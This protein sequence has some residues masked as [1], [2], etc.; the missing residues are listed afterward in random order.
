MAKKL[1]LD[2]SNYYSN[3]MAKQYIGATQIKDFM[4]CEAKAMARLNGEYTEEKSLALLVGS[5]TDVALT[6]T[7]EEMDKMLAENP[8]DFFCY[9]NPDKGFKAD[10]KKADKMIARVKSDPLM[11]KFLSGEHQVIMTGEIAGVPCKIKI[12]SYLKDKACVDLKTTQDMQKTVF[13]PEIGHRVSWIQAYRYPLQMALYREIIKQ[14][15]GKELP[16]YLVVVDKTE[17][18]DIGIFQI[19]SETMDMELEN[20]KDV[21]KHIDMVKKGQVKPKRCEC[22]NYC[23]KTKKAKILD[24]R[25]CLGEIGGDDE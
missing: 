25:E 7:Q 5:Y 22:C 3:D 16:C 18:P 17:E 8:K 9:G 15:T 24:W 14:N 23:K 1:K 12:D 10:F 2:E 11:M 6:G 20:I 4:D 21:V 13:D 19:D